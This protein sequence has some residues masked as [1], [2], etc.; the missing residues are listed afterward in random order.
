ML[1][2]PD[3]EDL[4]L[5]PRP[6]P[7]VDI[8]LLP[9]ELRA[10]RMQKLAVGGGAVLVIAVVLGL[11]YGPAIV[12]RFRRAAEEKP[13]DAETAKLAAAD[14]AEVP[15]PIEV[16]DPIATSAFAQTVPAMRAA[17]GATSATSATSTT[18]T[19][20]TSLDDGTPTGPLSRSESKFGTAKSW[21]EALML[22][23]ASAAEA[24]EIIAAL[25]KVV[26]FRRG[27]PADLFVFERDADKQLRSFEYRGGIMDV[28]RASRTETGALRGFKVQIP[29]ESR[30]IAKG[31]YI[32]GSLGHSLSA[33]SLGGQLAGSV[34][35]AFDGRVTFTKD[36]RAGDSVKLIVNEE[37]VDGTFL[38]Y[39]A[40]QAVEYSGERAGKLQAFWFEPGKGEGEFFE[41]SGRAVHGG[42]LRTPLRYDHVSSP[43]NLKR[44]H[45]ILKRI[46]PHLGIDYSAS[47]GTPVFAA[48]DGVVTFAG[49]R[50]PNGNLVSVKHSNGFESHYAHLWRIAPGIRPGAKVQQR[51][52]IGFVGSTG[53]S[54]GPHLHFA[55]KRGGKF[56][57][58]AS[59]LNGPGDVMASSQLPRFKANMQR[60]RGELERIPLAPAPS[61][62][63]MPKTEEPAD[64]EDLDL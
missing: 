41:A 31:T 30:R 29:I 22:G 2:T 60:L 15:T 38:R 44:R 12:A 8:A 16:R 6:L 45:P 19:P 61:I 42:W 54:T 13:V 17:T 48:A 7:S 64:D 35:E 57:D 14:P 23:G 50:G 32:A 4:P 10:A 24:N 28:Y 46:M 55:L 33:L 3:E 5:R 18:S 56:L 9:H 26:D 39:S 36:T 59:Q 43:Y 21:H 27:K 47:V 62:D 34:I 11:A 20:K 1:R 63:T 37:Y 53:R 49:A 58:P 40:V 52:N 51:Q 25:Q